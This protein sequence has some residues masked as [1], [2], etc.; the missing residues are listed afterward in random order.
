M[1]EWDI[2]ESGRLIVC[3]LRQFQAATGHETFCLLRLQF[4]RGDDGLE[5]PWESLQ[6]AMSVVQAK[7]LA[8][9][10][11]DAVRRVERPPP[12]GEPKN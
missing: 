1:D 5:T 10:L 12:A 2:D 11:L 6:L 8:V 4:E 3:P 9:D 7:Q